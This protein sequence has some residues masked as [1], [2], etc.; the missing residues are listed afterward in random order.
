MNIVPRSRYGSRA[1]NNLTRDIQ[2]AR[3][4]TVQTGSSPLNSFLFASD[5]INV[6]QIWVF[7]VD[8][9]VRRQAEETVRACQEQLTMFEEERED[10]DKR[11]AA[12][13][14]E[15]AKI[16]ERINVI[17]KRKEAD[18]NVQKARVSLE[19]RLSASELPFFLTGTCFNFV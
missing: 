1:M 3:N 6:V 5:L 7:S 2:R 15:D 10:L 12:M 13:K 19:G 4:L 18:R 16:E 17:K 9:E 11:Q 8:P 14:A